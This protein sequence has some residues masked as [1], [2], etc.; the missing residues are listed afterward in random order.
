M[1]MQQKARGDAMSVDSPRTGV[2]VNFLI[3]ASLLSVVVLTA[4]VCA[5]AAGIM[6]LLR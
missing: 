2:T 3:V 1:D 5:F 6:V 4:V